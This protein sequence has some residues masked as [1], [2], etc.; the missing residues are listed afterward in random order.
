[1][2]KSCW[3]NLIRQNGITLM[4]LLQ[5]LDQV[6]IYQNPL[7]QLRS[8][9]G[10]FPQI[11]KL[12]NGELLAFYVISEAFESVDAQTY[13]SRSKDG[14]YTWDQGRPVFDMQR[15]NLD[16]PVSEYL[17]PTLLRNGQIIAVGYRFDRNNPDLP[18]GNPE[19][20]GLL[21]GKNAVS[22]S[23]DSGQTWSVPA[24]IETGYS[25]LL[26]VSGP[27]VELESGELLALGSPFKCW[28]GSNPTGQYGF[29]LRSKDGGK[30]WN[31]RTKFFDLQGA[32]T[33]W[34][35]RLCQMADG[36]LV[37]I[38]WCYDLKK[39]QS[40][41]NHVVFS[42][43]NGHTWSKPLDTG[44]MAQASN[45]LGI[46]DD[47]LLTIHAHRSGQIGLAVRLVDIRDDKWKML[48]EEF[49]WGNSKNANS[50]GN[51]IEQFAT[52][53]FGQPS[54]LKVSNHE[55]I[56]CFWC[57]EDCIGKIKAIRIELKH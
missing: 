22:F 14:G 38:S 47:R 23:T 10:F 37:A 48:A 6:V 1:M 11:V 25:E 18:I 29:L 52:L 44:I 33:P 3:R 5:L 51:I 49:I 8:R 39:D 28:N 2:I 32:V 45:L 31:C 19:T 57:V 15:R 41:S 36:R 16:Y 50:S 17:K 7:P 55:L 13:F 20:G 9:H 26:E 24:V 46:G 35:S 21:P 43:D 40:L 42:H 30:K 27:C 4:S 53:K 56:A 12:E 54:L 34:E